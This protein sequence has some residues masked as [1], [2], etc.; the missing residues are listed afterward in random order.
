VLAMSA[1]LHASVKLLG[2][3]AEHIDSEARER[4]VS[5]NALVADY[6]IRGVEAARGQKDSDLRSFERRMSATI[7]AARGDIEAIQ[8]EVDTLTAMFD[9]FVKL[10]LLHLPEPVLD[11][12][13]AV[14]SS[15]LTRYE[16]FLKQ[17]AQTG[18]DGDR[19]RALRK[20]AKLL[21]QRILVE[22]ESPAGG[23]DE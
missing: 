7:L 5:K 23:S 8:S 9:L 17:V 19:P 1:M 20:I 10:M 6:V 14:Q 12:A 16:R 21:E 3:Y 22:D 13:E 2:G 15:A 11:E 4:G 18:F